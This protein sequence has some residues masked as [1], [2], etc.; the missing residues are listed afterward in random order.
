MVKIGARKRKEEA[1]KSP[2]EGAAAKSA[3]GRL[4]QQSFKRAT[5]VGKFPNIRHLPAPGGPHQLT[6]DDRRRLLSAMELV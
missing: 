6:E 2:T 3:T 4:Q 1:H 5:L